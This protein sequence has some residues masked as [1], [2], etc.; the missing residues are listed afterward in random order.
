MHFKSEKNNAKSREKSIFSSRC[1]SY[2]KLA[3]GA[4]Y[5]KCTPIIKAFTF[6]DFPNLELESRKKS[7]GTF[8]TEWQWCKLERCDL[9][10]LLLLLIFFSHS[11]TNYGRASVSNETKNED[12]EIEKL[13]IKKKYLTPTMQN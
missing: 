3:A 2:W 13:Y 6:D 4:L 11:I 1:E 9:D 8:F 12:M 7:F 10:F 5:Q